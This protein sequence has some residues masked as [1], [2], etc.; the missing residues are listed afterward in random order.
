[1]CSKPILD[2]KKRNFLGGIKNVSD[3]DVSAN[4]ATR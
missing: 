4:S 3:I 2:S 1:M